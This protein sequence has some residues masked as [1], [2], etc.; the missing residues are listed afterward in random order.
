MGGIYIYVMDS[1]RYDHVNESLTSNMLALASDGIN[2]TNAVAPATW[3][4][5]SAMSILTGL[6][7]TA[8]AKFGPYKP[9]LRSERIALPP[10]V[11]TIATLFKASGYNTF[12]YSANVFFSP[13]YRMDRGFDSMPD[14]EDF[15]DIPVR[16]ALTKILAKR[17]N[18]RVR[19][20]SFLTGEDLHLMRRKEQIKHS[21]DKHLTFIWT[22]DTHEPYFN[23]KFVDSPSEYDGI[24]NAR[25]SRGKA[26]QIYL[27]VVHY[28]DE[29]FGALVNELKA[30]NQYD[31]S[32][33][34]VLADHGECF[35]EHNQFGH[36]GVGFEPLIHIPFIMKLP[37]NDLA[38]SV[39]HEQVGLID[40]L[41]TLADLYQI[42][43][44][45][46]VHGKSLLPVI[47]SE[48]SGHDK[49]FVYDETHDQY[50]SHGV[51]RRADG[52][53]YVFRQRN[54]KKLLWRKR[55]RL[56]SN[57]RTVIRNILPLAGQW[58]FDLK[59][60]PN[61]YNNI[62]NWHDGK[63]EL[64]QLEADFASFSTE[65]L[66]YFEKHIGQQQTIKLPDKVKERMR[67]LGYLH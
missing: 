6:Y 20:V 63:A 48:A 5:P 14:A 30:N 49:L 29:Q 15:P 21:D 58:V 10:N 66:A 61:E 42:Q 31:S 43:M 40:I 56:K 23:R 32:T 22:M 46:S 7:P 9:G 53:K 24:T 47:H 35:G 62:L 25:F 52:M 36:A 11:E 45:A 33:I 16:D 65:M 38:G 59:V 50:W 2:F 8:I 19:R 1:L 13:F 55:S 28:S 60:D 44:G 67:N 3:S 37:G 64:E 17:L 12:A 27:A 26:Q 57:V 54:P 18:Q 39:C 4:L 41:P 51:V 34:I